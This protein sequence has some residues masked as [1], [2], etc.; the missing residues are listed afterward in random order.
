MES[1]LVRAV[2][3]AADARAL[4][5]LDTSFTTDRVFDV[6]VKNGEVCLRA[7]AV[8]PPVHKRFPLQLNQDAWEE[9]WV[10]IV[11][12][13]VVGFVAVAYSAWNRRLVIW[14]YYVDGKFRGRG[15]G[16][17]LMNQAVLRAHELGAKTVWVE[18]SNLNFPGVAAYRRLGFEICGFDLTLYRGTD[19]PPGEFAL[20]LARPIEHG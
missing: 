5:D 19:G 8:S 11:S 12:G 2:D 6:K 10:A 13:D 1:M 9:G 4:S 20:F 7:V 15:F 16:R 14:H 17:R 3:V 18:T